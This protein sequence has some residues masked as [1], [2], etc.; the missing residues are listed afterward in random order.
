MKINVR[1]WNQLRDARGLVEES[2][3]LPEG[4]TVLDLVHFIVAENEA[5]Y[6]WLLNPDGQL[7][8]WILV[9]RAGLMLR[10]AAT[11]L[12]D[13]DEIQLLTHVSGG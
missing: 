3:E 7:L 5:M 11:I 4:S 10:D 6:S 9:D 8:R 2:V 12:A 1:Y 13:G